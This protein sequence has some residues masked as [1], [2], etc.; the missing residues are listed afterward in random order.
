MCQHIK[1]VR[2]AL[3]TAVT[4]RTV[5]QSRTSHEAVRDVL[6]PHER[7]RAGC[8]RAAP[9]AEAVR[10]ALGSWRG[11]GCPSCSPR[12]PAPALLSPAAPALRAAP[13]LPRSAQLAA[14]ASQCHDATMR[15][16]PALSRRQAR[17]DSFIIRQRTKGGV[18]QARCEAP[19]SLERLWG[20][21]RA[22]PRNGP[23]S[24]SIGTRGNLY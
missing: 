17:T 14:A 3:I 9:R 23:M 21:G 16:Y 20:Q 15:H 10:A 6:R 1:H 5:T 24:R 11:G 8:A 13:R 7:S 19:S 2:G 18:E 4:R 22:K 12:L